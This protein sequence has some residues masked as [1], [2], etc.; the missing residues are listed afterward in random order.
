MGIRMMNKYFKRKKTVNRTAVSIAISVS[1][2]FERLKS[3]FPNLVVEELS[4]TK[5]IVVIQ[6][7]PDV[8]SR[9]YDVKIVYETGKSVL[10]FIVN[11]KLKIAE[12]RTKLPH[13]WDNE[14]QKICLYS[15]EG[16]KWSSEK[17]IISTVVPW[18]S[19]WLFYYELWLI[20]GLWK[21]GG[22]DEYANENDVKNEQEQI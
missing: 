15:R 11:E 1:S 20:D 13:V 9:E 10:V 8:F 4:K 7:R 12:N 2:Q 17:S 19:E 3:S 5:L 16:G 14:L 21:G 18:A 6:I 22:H